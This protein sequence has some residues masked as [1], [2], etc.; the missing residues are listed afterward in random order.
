MKFKKHKEELEIPEGIQV[1]ISDDIITIKGEK[2][3]LTKELKSPVINMC[4]EENKVVFKIEKMTKREKTLLG[5]FKSHT[6]NMMQGVTEPYVYK[7]KIC[8]G[9]FP[10]NITYS[11]QVLSVKNFIGEKIPRKL[12]VKKG[13]DLKVDGDVITVTSNDKE[14]AGQTAASIEL[15]CRRPGFDKRIFQQGIFI[16]EKAGKKV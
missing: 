12:E 13:V 16:T 7:L 11:N 10:M 3:E 1:S 4:V 15:L 6:K 8:S 2:G 9:H 14:L 5:T